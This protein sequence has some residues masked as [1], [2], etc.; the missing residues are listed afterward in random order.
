[1][2]KPIKILVTDSIHEVFIEQMQSIGCEVH[3]QNTIEREQVLEVIANYEVLLINSRI[4]ADKELIDKGTNLIAIARIGSGLE[5]IDTEYAATKNIA[6]INAPEGNKDAVAEHAL[7]MLLCLLNNIHIANAEVKAGQWLR[8]KN[9]GTELGGKTIGIIGFGSNGSA[10]AEK[11]KGFGV[12]ILAYDKYKKGFGNE[13]VTESNLEEIFKRAEIV[14]LHTPL[15]EETYHLVNN[16][17]ILAFYKHFYFLNMARGKNVNTPDLIN[18]LQTGKIL[19]ACLDV[20]ENEKLETLTIQEKQYFQQLTNM[21]NVLLTP[22]IA[23]WTYESKIKIANLLATK[24]QHLL[25][26]L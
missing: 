6:C 26:E 18:A 19:G 17:F 7:G 22:H 16:N 20:L 23:G 4:K 3:Y 21:N 11:L 13:Y 14:S 5:V 8:E 9:R 25:S 15:T 12:T 10:F 2:K 1:M 24:L